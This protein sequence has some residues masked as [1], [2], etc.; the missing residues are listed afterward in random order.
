MG[1]G[2]NEGNIT[3]KRVSDSSFPQPREGNMS[4]WGTNGISVDDINQGALGDC[5]LLSAISAL[6][7]V[8]H[9]IDDVF[10]NDEISDKGIYAMNMYTLGVPHTVIVDDYLP[11]NDGE[12]VLGGYGKDGSIWGSIL[13]KGYAKRYGNYEHLD[14]GWMPAAVSV[15]NGSPWSEYL[16]GET[17]KNAIWEIL[18]TADDVDNI[19]TTGTANSDADSGPMNIVPGHAYT[20]LSTVVL[21]TSRGDVKLVK[22]RNPW[23]SEEYTGPWSD[24]SSLWTDAHKATVEAATNTNAH[25]PTSWGNNGIFY[26]DLDSYMATMTDTAVNKHTTGWHLDYFLMFNDPSNVRTKHTLTVTNSGPA[27][28]VHVGTHIWQ[29]RSYSYQNTQCSNAINVD[30]S[31][32]YHSIGPSGG[33]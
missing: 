27:Q 2:Y 19:I 20:V 10:V 13:E 26:M 8:P 32:D 5:W 12:V 31:L 33:R 9:R 22:I 25:T 28:T 7:E 23:G 24:S 3:Y 30:D 4:F 29:D 21:S 16:H 11:L 17:D 18:Q 6:A 14:G 1:Q 15:L